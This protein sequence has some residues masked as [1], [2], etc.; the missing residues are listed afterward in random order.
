MRGTP[1]HPSSILMFYSLC[2]TWSFLAV[3]C[4][5][6]W[7]SENDCLITSC[8]LPP[9]PAPEFVPHPEPVTDAGVGRVKAI[10]KVDPRVPAAGYAPASRPQTP[11]EEDAVLTKLGKLRR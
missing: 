3:Q 2:L 6:N 7:G 9:P 5:K 4:L 11:S 10:I 1:G 8:A